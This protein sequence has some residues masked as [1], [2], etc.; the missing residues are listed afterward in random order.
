[1]IDLLIKKIAEENTGLEKYKITALNNNFICEILNKVLNKINISTSET[2]KI[3]KL[4]KQDL[5]LT[6]LEKETLE[7]IFLVLLPNHIQLEQVQ[8]DVLNKVLTRY[9][10]KTNKVL[11]EK[12]NLNNKLILA[13]QS[14]EIFLYF[15]EL[16]V[17]F[18]EY[19]I[20]LKDRLKIIK[21]LIHKN[22]SA[23]LEQKVVCLPTI[24]E[25][26]DI[27]IIDDKPDETV[28]NKAP[29]RCEEIISFF[30]KNKLYYAK[31]DDNLKEKI[32][33]CGLNIAEATNIIEMLKSIG[34]NIKN[35]YN[36]NSENFINLILFSKL[37]YMN[38]VISIVHKHNIDLKK[39]LN[40]DTRIFYSCEYGGLL[41]DFK[42]NIDFLDSL[43]YDYKDNTDLKLYYMVN[44]ELK[45]VYHLYTKVYRF[46]L[47]YPENICFLKR[48]SWTPILDRLI[49][50]S[51]RALTLV[52]QTEMDLFNTYN[53][54]LFYGL[55]IVE[56]TRDEEQMIDKLLLIAMIRSDN[57]SLKLT[58]QDDIQEE[59]TELSEQLN[60]LFEQ[61]EDGENHVMYA[62]PNSVKIDPE[63]LNNEYVNYL[64]TNYKVKDLAYIINRTRISRIKVLRVLSYLNS[65]GI[66]ITEDVVKYALKFN[67][68]YIEKDLDN[69]NSIFRSK[70]K[71]RK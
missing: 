9:S 14:E 35:Y 39:L 26:G 5:Q 36:S 17:L 66:D 34:V 8:K 18:K 13:L 1:M 20:N 64:E 61:L 44:E 31:L 56:T 2:N 32:N 3:L 19:D 52:E 67:Y 50:I 38:E 48:V 12:I 47:C 60:L 51:G 58:G 6:S 49:E 29:E 62:I 33:S 4:I 65:Q 68:I 40:F 15:D 10:E 71:N 43:D 42:G 69:I 46:R 28:V 21:A 24:E 7:F 63:V 23:Q 30:K 55:K 57:W 41:E 22:Y 11:S 16:N 25:V 37:E 54:T 59:K 53:R 70:E 27:T 45:N